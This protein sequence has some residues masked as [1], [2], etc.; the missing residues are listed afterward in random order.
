M[1]LGVI[2]LATVLGGGVVVVVFVLLLRGRRLS[3]DGEPDTTETDIPESEPAA[4]TDADADADATAD[5][6]AASAADPEAE[7][8]H[9]SAPLSRAPHETTAFTTPQVG[10]GIV[11]SRALQNRRGNVPAQVIARQL[12]QALDQGAINH[13]ID[14]HDTPVVPPAEGTVGSG[15][16][17]WWR[18]NGADAVSAAPHANLL[19]VNAPGG[20]GTYGSWCV[21]GAGGIDTNV[22]VTETRTDSIG[23]GVFAA[24]HECGHALGLAHDLDAETPGKQHT[25][26]GWNE[27]GRW[28]LTPMNVDHGVTNACGVAIPPRNHDTVA[29]HLTYTDCS[30]DRFVAEL[31]EVDS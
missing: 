17:V 11:E 12:S 25:G 13:R 31:E 16:P 27:D 21:V 28:H 10:I 19:L 29:Y 30:I 22:S 20:G 8:S 6:D 4:A 14:V 24:L 9:D 23:A 2:E 5:S 26:E 7:T 3:T 1:A 15:T 18:D